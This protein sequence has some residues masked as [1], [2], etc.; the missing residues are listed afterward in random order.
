MKSVYLRSNR[1][2]VIELNGL[3][4]LS[5]PMD[6]HNNSLGYLQGTLGYSYMCHQEQILPVGQNFS[7]NT[8]HLQV[9]PFGVIGNEFGA[10]SLIGTPLLF[11]LFSPF[12]AHFYKNTLTTSYMYAFSTLFDSFLLSRGM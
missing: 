2:K 3:S 8:F 7:L 4:I 9:Q 10:G 6:V 11:L 12:G 5:G 1:L